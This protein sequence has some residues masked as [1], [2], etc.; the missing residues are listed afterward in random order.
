MVSVVLERIHYHKIRCYGLSNQNRSALC[1][2][3]KAMSA[4]LA[5][6]TPCEQMQQ[7]CPI[8]RVKTNIPVGRTVWCLVAYLSWAFAT[9]VYFAAFE[10]GAKSSSGFA[11]NA[12]F[13]FSPPQPSTK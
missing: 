13:C 12:T 10:K 7:P 3:D 11:S 8:Q 1:A 5:N 4:A 9:N 2:L 6:G